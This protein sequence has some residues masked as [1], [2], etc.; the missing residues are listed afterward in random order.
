MKRVLALGTLCLLT[1]ARPAAHSGTIG[2]RLRRFMH[3][4]GWGYAFV[5]PSVLTF[6]VCAGVGFRSEDVALISKRAASIQSGP[7][8]IW[9]R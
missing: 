3:R 4:Y 9:K 6:I 8:V 7:P 2:D 5:L 1:A